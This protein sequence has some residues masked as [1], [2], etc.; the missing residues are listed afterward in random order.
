MADSKKETETLK[1]EGYDD[2]IIPSMLYTS[3]EIDKM[4]R[5]I[6]EIWLSIDPNEENYIQKVNIVSIQCSN[7]FSYLVKN[8]TDP[9]P[10]PNRRIVRDYKLG[11]N[12]KSY[13]DTKNAIALEYS[14]YLRKDTFEV[15]FLVSIETLFISQIVEGFFEHKIWFL[16]FSSRFLKFDGNV[17]NSPYKFLSHDVVHAQFSFSY[18]FYEQ[19]QDDR[20][21]Y[22]SVYN[23]NRNTN[24]GYNLVRDFYKYCKMKYKKGSKEITALQMAIFMGMHEQGTDSDCKIWF[25]NSS[26]KDFKNNIKH[27]MKIHYERFFNKNDLFGSIPK[28]IRDSANT[29]EDKPSKEKIITDYLENEVVENYVNTYTEWQ[30]DLLDRDGGRKTRRRRRRRHRT[31]KR[32][33]FIAKDRGKTSAYSRPSDSPQN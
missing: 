4:K 23:S 28:R 29:A 17:W 12:Y 13:V 24:A 2:A 32:R 31:N 16:G 14:G 15:Y 9:E 19:N 21:C 5:E 30:K 22:N 26:E 3:E 6:D 27:E 18:T 7:M 11:I 25:G 33:R 20:N 10:N 8:R 1:K